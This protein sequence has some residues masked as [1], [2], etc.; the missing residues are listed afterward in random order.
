[1]DPTS[2]DLWEVVAE[3]TDGLGVDATVICVG[4]PQLVNDALRVTRKGGRVN[5][6][7]GLAGEG[8]AEVEANLV[9]YNELVLSGA[10]DSR[11]RDYDTAL[12]LIESGPRSGG[13]DDHA[14][15]PA[16][17]RREGHRDVGRRRGHQ[18]GRDAVSGL[19]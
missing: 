6:F 5:V 7:A 11:R 13:A 1:V 4:R 12:R 16:K 3:H 17:G 9:H 14:P 15:L 2:E 18:G 19:E 10:S 8:W